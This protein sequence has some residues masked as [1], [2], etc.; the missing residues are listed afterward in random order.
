MQS[1]EN[2]KLY[3]RY[4][5]S[6]CSFNNE[7]VLAWHWEGMFGVRVE[8][9]VVIDVGQQVSNR[10]VHGTPQAHQKGLPSL[11]PQQVCSHSQPTSNSTLSF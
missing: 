9:P 5:I 1:K 4:L 7:T 6:G 11:E 3:L 10:V 8:P 2:F